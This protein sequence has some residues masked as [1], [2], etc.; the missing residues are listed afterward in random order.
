MYRC[1]SAVSR[2]SK[3]TYGTI[4]HARG[5]GIDT[6]R[7]ARGYKNLPYKPPSMNEMPTP[8]GSWA[9]RYQRVQRTY[10]IQL[11]AAI[12]FAG[13]TVFVAKQTGLVDFQWGPG[14]PKFAKVVPE[15][16]DEEEAPAEE[17][18]AEE[19]V[20]APVE[21]APA[22]IE[23]APAPIEEAPA[24]VEEA[25]AAPVEEAPAAPVEEAPAAPAEEAPAA[26][27]EEPAAPVEEPPAAPAEEAP[28]APAE[29]APA[30][31]AEE[32]PAAPADTEA[33][34]VEPVAAQTEG[35]ES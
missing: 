4:N 10:N 28:A 8:Q 1:G 31:P 21:E 23:E 17:A 11:G 24:P 9:Q 33:P 12:G 7:S 29:E 30:A 18:P 35:S 6:A 22:P 3:P 14:K 32:A 15:A 25:P 19:E 34:V 26:P 27:V 16:A 20:A 13:F 5:R 2:V